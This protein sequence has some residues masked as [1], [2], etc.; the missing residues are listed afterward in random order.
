MTLRVAAVLLLV[1]ALLLSGCVVQDVKPL[2][3]IEPQ[4]AQRQIPADELLDVV[5]HTFDPGIP[6]D[7]AEDEDALAKKRIYPDLRKAES[8]YLAVMLRNTLESSAQWGAVRVGPSTVQFV[9]LAV[10]GRIVE[11]TGKRL[12]LEITARDATGRVWIDKQHYASEA[13]LGSYK[14]DASLKARDP[15]QNVF[16]NIANDLL[17]ARDRFAAT[18]LRELRQ[19]AQLQFAQDIAPEAMSGYLTQP[20]AGAKAAFTRVARLP[21]ENDPLAQRIERI[22]ERDAAVVD[23]LSGY[24]VG[25]AEQM[26]ESYG[27]F[28]R[29]SYEEVE[30]EDRARTSARTRTLLGAAAVAASIFVPSSCSSNSSCRMDS[31]LRYGGAAGGV[32]AVLSGLKKYAD[33]RT[34][35]Q[36]FREL[37]TSFQAE[38]APQVVDVEG[39]SLK[40]SGTAEEQYREW[41]K[42]LREYHEQDVGSVSAN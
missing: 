34:H 29:T 37:A 18:Q 22:H 41:R 40:L 39:R 30:K 28:R 6:E 15:F 9:D 38:V 8:R 16:S 33:A 24:Y 27:S 12:E 35:A 25:F 7:L 31:A 3:K 4:Q 20:A 14:T 1:P 42:L 21:A 23:T 19:V 11:S 5:V 2:A 13:D 36:S 32:A 10:D 26:Q 17:A